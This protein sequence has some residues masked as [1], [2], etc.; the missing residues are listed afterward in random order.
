MRA[1]A[2]A[3]ALGVCAACG[4]SEPSFIPW[5][6]DLSDAAM[7]F[8]LTLSA[9]GGRVLELHPAF[10]LDPAG[11]LR[12]ALGAGNEGQ[13]LLLI[14]D[15]QALRATGVERADRPAREHELVE[16]EEPCGR[17]R[18]LGSPGQPRVRL[19]SPAVTRLFALPGGTS[20]LQGAEPR[21]Y[22][23]LARLSVEVPIAGSACPLV[24]AHQVESFDLSAPE[25]VPEGSTVFGAPAGGGE[26][27]PLA[28][29]WHEIEVLDPDWVVGLS[30][31]AL[32]Q[33]R[34]GVPY[35][36]QPAHRLGPPDVRG[37]PV[38]PAN[39][40]SRWRWAAVSATPEAI[41]G[42]R[43]LA[44]LMHETIATTGRARR[45]ALVEVLLDQSGFLSATTSSVVSDAL[46]A[47]L[48]V[49]PSAVL[50]L[51]DVNAEGDATSSSLG[52]RWH[53]PSPAGPWTRTLLPR[54]IHGNTLA[55][56]DH[57]SLPHL[58]G[59]AG[60]EILVGDLGQAPEQAR[61]VR[62]AVE[63]A[64]TGRIQGLASYA[65]GAGHQLWAGDNKGALFQGSLLSVELQPV[66]LRHPP[67]MWSCRQEVDD[68]GWPVT[69]DWITSIAPVAQ[70][71]GIAATVFR[72]EH[73]AV[74]RSE[75]L[76]ISVLPLP[77]SRAAGSEHH[78]LQRHGARLY[79]SRRSSEVYVVDAP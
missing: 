24:E 51:G 45:T 79:L 28:L 32:F 22:P 49:G 56:T 61:L 63:A 9:D 20:E 19:P 29:Q 37:L 13:L 15:D 44:A 68:C 57:P 60:G 77:T 50:A 4:S 10:E 58:G 64:R 71:T 14:L 73:V 55:R 59:F 27:R 23:V 8:A 38:L 78:R 70:A 67:E 18:L 74:L 16:E 11:P 1:R 21:D 52:V 69:G 46:R 54:V 48:A 17:G 6:A 39:G 34:R 35:E 66:T 3:L 31:D 53:G 62:T 76:C 40:D 26:S 43:R 2:A 47:V 72:C 33:V 5:P 41:A 25:L 36:D 65:A 42:R 12:L 75:D 30:W 7:G